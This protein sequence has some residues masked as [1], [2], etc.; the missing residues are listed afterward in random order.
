MVM[1]A[2]CVKFF[3]SLIVITC[4]VANEV[5]KDRVFLGIGVA[6]A[7]LI[8]PTLI[9]LPGL[10]MRHNVSETLENSIFKKIAGLISLI[11][12]LLVLLRIRS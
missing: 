10:S 8:Y 12:A 11:M 3:G 4:L 6:A 7:L 9:F 5:T 1:T 2:N